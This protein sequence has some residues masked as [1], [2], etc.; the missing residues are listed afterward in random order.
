MRL[1]I[2]PAFSV[3]LHL[4]DL[5]GLD[6]VKGYYQIRV[7]VKPNPTYSSNLCK[8]VQ[9]SSREDSNDTLASNSIGCSRVAKIVNK[10]QCVELDNA[11][12]CKI[13]VDK[14]L[15]NSRQCFCRWR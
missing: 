1:E 8:E 2:F 12:R 15:D 14:R 4:H 6:L 7:F 13:N 9:F 3:Y 5:I 11:F 10:E